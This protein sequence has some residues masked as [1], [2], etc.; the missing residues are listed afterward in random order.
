MAR[1]SIAPLAGLVFRLRSVFLGLRAPVRLRDTAASADEPARSTPGYTLPAFQA[2]A[3]CSRSRRWLALAIV[4]EARWAGYAE[5]RTVAI[6]GDQARKTGTRN[7]KTHTMSMDRP[8]TK[9]WFSFQFSLA[10]LLF[11][12]VM[13]GVLLFVNFQKNENW[14]LEYDI[15]RGDRGPP[16]N[17]REPFFHTTPGGGYGW[18]YFVAKTPGDPGPSEWSWIGLC[19][20]IV[21]GCAVLFLLGVL[22]EM[23]RRWKR[24]RAPFRF[25]RREWMVLAACVIALLALSW[26]P[27]NIHVP[28]YRPSGMPTGPLFQRV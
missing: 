6:P 25:T 23:G 28:G 16:L 4:A 2:G 19:G 14:H 13:A 3:L 18:P 24:K 8:A 21:F 20:N 27:R 15:L 17:Q 1:G 7:L 12:S 9:S 11:M 10:S 5:R 22:F 26:W